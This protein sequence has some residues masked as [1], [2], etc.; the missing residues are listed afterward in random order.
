MD[1][2]SYLATTYWLIGVNIMF[3]IAIIWLLKT[4]K[5]TSISARVFGFVS[6]IWI[7]YLYIIFN[8]ELLIPSDISGNFFYVSTLTS[9]TLVLLFVYFSPLIKVLDI[10]IAVMKNHSNKYLLIRLAKIV[11]ILDIVIIV[12]SIFIIVWQDLG[13]FHNI[14]YVVFYTSVLLLWFHFVSISKLLKSK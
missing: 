8:K 3:L 7:I 4:G 13:T 1:T 11:D 5:A 12:T 6:F 14:Q 10:D 2:S 9:A